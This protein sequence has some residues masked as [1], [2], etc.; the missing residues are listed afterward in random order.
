M[1]SFDMVMNFDEKEND[2]LEKIQK[3]YRQNLNNFYNK[4]MKSLHSV[5][6]NDITK[7]FTRNK[8]V[9]GF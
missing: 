6:G 7:L 5:V 4:S 3:R 2:I 9:F 8:Y 1:W